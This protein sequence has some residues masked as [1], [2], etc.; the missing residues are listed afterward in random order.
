MRNAVDIAAWLQELGLER[1]EEAFRENEIDAEI[2]PKLTADDLKDIGVI[3]VGHRRKLLEAIA[4]LAEPALASQAGPGAPAET[5]PRT[6]SAAERRQLT[7][8][9][10]DLV[11]STELSAR[12]DPEDMGAL[13]RTYQECCAEGVKQWEGH[14]AKYMGDG[15]L[16]YFGYPRAHED[17][18]ERA[19]RAGLALIDAVG[20]MAVPSGETLAARVGIA[21]GLVMVG[22]LLG[23]GA[24]QELTVVGET[25]NLAARLQALAQ[26]G[27][28]VISQATRRLLGGLF[29]LTDLGPQRLR[30][31]AE[32]LTA[33]RVEGEGRAEGRFE[34]RQ[35]TGL[36]PLVGREEEIALLLRRWRQA[37][38]GEGQVVLLSGEPGIGKS[39]LVRELRA[40]L[41]AEPHIRLLY[42]CSPHHTTSPL[43]PLIE[44]LERAAGFAAGDR[45]EEKLD[46]LATLLARGT[47][48]P[49]QAVPL[50]AAL[51][52]LPTEGRY[53][54]LDLTPQRQKQLTLAA[55]VEQLEGLAAAQP[56]L[57]AYEDMHWSDPTTQELLGLTIERLQRLPVLLLITYRPDF[58]PPWPAKPHV[59]AMA[60]SRLGR[61]EG[62]ALVERVIRD[63]ALPDEVLEQ[64]L[65]KTDGVPLFVEELTKTVVES[66]LLADAGDHYELDG[67][68]PPL[69]IPATL[70]D[71]LMA[72]LDRLAAAKEAAQ[73]AAVIGR[74]FSHELLAAV[75]PLSEVD[76]SAALDQLL[77]AELIFRRGAPPDATYSFKHTLVQDAAYQ[78]LLR[79]RRQQL[80][81]KIAEV[82]QER[83]TRTAPE[84]VARHC[85]EARLN[86]R[87]SMYWYEVGQWAMRRS[88]YTEALAHLNAGL[89][90]LDDIHVSP[91]RARQALRLQLTRAEALQATQGYI[92]QET[93]DA[94]SNALELAREVG[95]PVDIFPALRGIHIAYTQ[96][97]DNRSSLP[98][99]DEC[100]QLAL[101]Q[102][103]RAAQSLAHRIMG[104]SSMFLGD[105]KTAR[106]H[107]EQAHALYDSKQHHSSATIYGLDLRAATLNFLSPT[108]W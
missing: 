83:L 56:V 79:S 21:T 87:A 63:K 105:L 26:P 7:V 35:T 31:F 107:L 16:A 67:S 66:G 9:F 58:S 93:M 28:V 90:V 102:D 20:R 73:T 89:K 49:E 17:D 84:V 104:Q 85:S 51:L 76:L 70:H 55:L 27:S 62:A 5:T 80:H 74:E 53:P 82:L 88:A 11:G 86:D 96:Q 30:G 92:A 42:Q 8:M 13:I 10:C 60:L 50:I 69:A 54:A 36:T 108:L 47:D 14:I 23:E 4:A 57:L 75:S 94:Y 22:D 38:D 40:R 78:S 48:R 19:V 12:L 59:S 39:R 65:A 15:V 97:G 106:D 71:S 81:G 52:G 2:L 41:E 103:D 100:L 18:G 101:R 29:E 43:H 68:L 77:Q 95:C 34:A 25:P 72:R 99:G 64:I 45:A 32:P 3:T 61:R 24:A 98:V 1:Y 33:W 46:K 6:R 91:Q 37:A 44:Q